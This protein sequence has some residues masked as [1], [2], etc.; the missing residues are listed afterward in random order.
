MTHAGIVQL[1]TVNHLCRQKVWNEAV[2][3]GILTAKELDTVE[4]ALNLCQRA[5]CETWIEEAKN[6][7]ALGKIRTDC[8]LANAS[9]FQASILAYNTLLQWEKGV[10]EMGTQNDQSLFNTPGRETVDWQQKTGTAY[11]AKYLIMR[12]KE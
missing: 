1:E 7:M 6:Q 2:R 5:T 3:K 10:A 8:F 12:R 9:L 4:S 11:I